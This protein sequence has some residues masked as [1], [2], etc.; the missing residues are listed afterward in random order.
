MDPT[1]IASMNWLEMRELAKAKPR[2]GTA[3]KKIMKQHQ[4]LEEFMAMIK[5]RF[6]L[7]V[8]CSHVSEIVFRAELEQK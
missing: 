3:I 2:P 1:T 4:Y 5:K 7:L 8:C 6:A